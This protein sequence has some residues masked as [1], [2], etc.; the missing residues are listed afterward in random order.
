MADSIT[1]QTV[2]EQSIRIWAKQLGRLYPSE[3]QVDVGPNVV[4]G[5]VETMTPGLGT[6]VVCVWEITKKPLAIQVRLLQNRTLGGALLEG[7]FRPGAGGLDGIG[8]IGYLG[9]F[10]SH[11]WQVFARIM[12][13]ASSLCGSILR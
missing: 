4:R 12:S 13:A 10:R 11:Q 6:T 3:T 5:T 7:S 2:P 1:P 9:P 8:R